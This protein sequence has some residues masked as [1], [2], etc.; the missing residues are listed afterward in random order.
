[1]RPGGAPT[2]LRRC[3]CMTNCLLGDRLELA[4]HDSCCSAATN[5]TDPWLTASYPPCSTDRAR[6]G[7]GTNATTA[8]P[9]YHEQGSDK[10]GR[11]GATALETAI[12]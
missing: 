11:S 2:A 3:T 6:N 9:V 7:H 12:G 1:M 8:S 4:R 5:Q 10:A